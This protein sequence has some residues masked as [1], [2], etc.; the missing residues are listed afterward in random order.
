MIN[1]Y[2]LIFILRH[3]MNPIRKHEL[4]LLSEIVE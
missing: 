4:P 2:S 3:D 1:L